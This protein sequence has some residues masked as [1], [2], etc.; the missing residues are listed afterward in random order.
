VLA[1]VRAAAAEPTSVAD[2]TFEHG[3]QLMAQK[4]YAE[5]CTAFEQSQQLDPQLGTLFNIAECDAQ[6]GKVATA[7]KLYRQLAQTD[8]NLDRRKLSADAAK[9]LEPQLPHV[10]ISVTAAPDGTKVQLDGADA[11]AL[12]G[13]STPIDAGHHAITVTAPGYRDWHGATE[14]ALARTDR[15]TVQLEK[16]D[17]AVVTPPPQ[18]PLHLTTGPT[19]VPAPIDT[20]R[21]GKLP[22]I[23]GASTLGVG[24]VLGGV[25]YSEYHSAEHCTS[26]DA[27]GQSH[28]AVVLGDVSTAVVVVGAVA[29]VGGL[30]L[31]H[32]SGSSAMVAPS[33]GQD[34]AG[35]VIFGRF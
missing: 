8:S 24:L 11:T 20:P 27:H 25:A 19:P 5:A 23:I 28:T 35:A 30:Y 3:R 22:M 1:L 31:W 34:H 9:Q 12:L 32:A 10:L 26:C 33:V 4:K 14:S 17:N 21:H 16:G 7:W 29:L 15:V 6:Q 2:Q 18:Q 13:V